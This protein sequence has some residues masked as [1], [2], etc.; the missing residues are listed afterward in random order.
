M[1]IAQAGAG[2]QAYAGADG[3]YR[4][5]P[6]GLIINADPGD[7]I[8]TAVKAGK[9]AVQVIGRGHIVY[10]HEGFRH[11]SAEIK[12]HRGTLPEYVLFAPAFLVQ[13]TTAVAQTDD[14]GAG[15]FIAGDIAVGPAQVFKDLFE[16][17]GQTLGGGAEQI[18]R[19]GP[20]LI[21]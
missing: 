2:A 5:D 20:D 19:R 6:V 15:N 8:E 18:F 1:Q 10:Q 12:S 7:E 11:I 14:K 9:T 3:G 21:F 13:L 17:T 4:Q 16:D